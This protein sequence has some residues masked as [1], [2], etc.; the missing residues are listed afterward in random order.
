MD[1]RKKIFN[2]ISSRMGPAFF[3]NEAPPVFLYDTYRL[4]RK[5]KNEKLFRKL[6]AVYRRVPAVQC[7]PCG[8]VCCRESPDAYLLEYLYIWRHIRYTLAD[9]ELEKE[10][11]RRALEWTFLRCVKPDVY[12]PFLV[13]KKCVIY[14][15]RPL[16]CRLWALEDE[17]YYA[18]KAA[19]AGEQVEKQAE[20]FRK[21]GIEPAG[22]PARGVLP[23]CNNITVEGDRRYTEDEI[24]SM[25][26]D[27]AF[28]HL[29]LIPH[30]AFRS[31]NF[32]LHIPGH[33]STK[34]AEIQKFDALNLEIAREYSRTGASGTL[35]R[36][37]A[38]FEGCLP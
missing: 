27:V 2:E 9:P 5:A 11:L 18:K 22:A 33:I 20:F 6:D 37:A 10:I 26:L 13:D 21:N 32:H 29:T 23:R 25:D 15:V 24:V 4:Q 1:I 3:E 34:K 31:M 19:R 7:G 14:D 16:N 28:L 17:Q 12:C 38:S 30:E 36:F 8:D 35:Q